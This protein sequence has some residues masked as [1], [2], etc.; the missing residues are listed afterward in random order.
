MSTIRIDIASEFKEKGFKK[1]EKATSTLDDKFKKLGGTI[2][3][4]FS[5]QQV[6]NFGRAAMKAFID[7]EQAAIRF[8]QALKGVNLGFA[9]PEVERY[10]DTLEKQTAVLKDDLRPAFQTLA[11]TT[12][13]VYKSQDILNTAIDVA[14]GSGV[15]LQTVIKDLSRSY[16]GNN[17]ALSKYNLGLSKAELK[18]TSFEKVQELLNK[19]FAGQRAAYLETYAGKLEL[20]NLSYDRM[21]ETVG[22]AL[23]D[24]FS[25]LIG[26]GGI[27]GATT[28]MENFGLAA[29][30]AIRGVGI[31]VSTI[32][33][34]IPFLDQLQYLS[35][36]PQAMKLLNMLMDLGKTQRPL[37]FPTGGIGQPALDAKMAK[38]EEERIKREKELER[39][40]NKSLREQEKANRLKRISIMLME[41]ERKFDITRIQLQ[42]ALQGKLTDEERRRVEELLLIE[43]IKE[44][45]AK[46]N[47]DEAEALLDKLNDLQARTEKLALSLTTFPKA[48]D[49][50]A[51][52]MKSLE[53]IMAALLAIQGISNANALAARSAASAGNAAMATG[54]FY[55]AQAAASSANA[56]ASLAIA[57]AQAAVAAATTPEEKA[58]AEEFLEAA[59]A[60]MDAAGILE[61]SAAALAVAA[62][63]LETLAAAD[64]LGESIAATYAAGIAPAQVVVNVAGNVTTEQ[65]LV[66][67]VTE[68]LYEIQRR[69]Q[70]V[71]LKAIAL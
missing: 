7:D 50:F 20:I 62:A 68:G 3:A 39:L 40:R 14:A 35:Q 10:L 64:L 6:I 49:P 31:L 34:R 19:Q 65:D 48:N 43:Q 67:A 44:E 54:D 55:A 58:A 18:T 8:E 22:G 11:Q 4:V 29:G 17:A 16:L 37:F 41:K 12:R 30:D 13:S 23:L 59:N 69:G 24:S 5:T 45:V 71:T 63:S 38:L 25:M 51:D 36:F 53:K 57:A 15:D 47:V 27:G 61:E 33:Q 42:A 32:Q 1:A 26:E 66:T 2:A 56:D 70:S 21:Q 28:A 60:S 9:T 46:G 52:W